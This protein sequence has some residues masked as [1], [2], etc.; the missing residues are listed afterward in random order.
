MTREVE[1]AQTLIVSREKGIW[2]LLLRD[3]LKDDSEWGKAD[4]STA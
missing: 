2:G 1:G 4:L 3:E